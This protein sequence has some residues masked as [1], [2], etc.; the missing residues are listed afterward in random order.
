[1]ASLSAMI[2]CRRRFCPA[3]DRFVFAQR[4]PFPFQFHATTAAITLGLWLPVALTAGA[5]HLAAGAGYRCPNCRGRCR[6]PVPGLGSSPADP[7]PVPPTPFPDHR[8][9]TGDK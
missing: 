7:Y 4:H 8:P 6:R 5:W 2:D 9:G 1:M 3:C